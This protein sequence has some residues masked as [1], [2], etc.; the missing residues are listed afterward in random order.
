MKDVNEREN[1]E[2]KGKEREEG[3]ENKEEVNIKLSGS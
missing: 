1:K 2:N 3:A